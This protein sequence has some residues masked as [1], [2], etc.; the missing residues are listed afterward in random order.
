MPRPCAPRG[1]SGRS[2]AIPKRDDGGD[3][4]KR[5]NIPGG[6]RHGGSA[7]QDQNEGIGKAGE[8]PAHDPQAASLAY[9]VRS[10]PTEAP[11]GVGGR[12]ASGAG[13][14]PVHQVANVD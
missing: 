10:V 6:R 13:I 7:E 4:R 12:E 9:L 8:Q 5:R 2:P 1:T 11:D 14:E 3:D